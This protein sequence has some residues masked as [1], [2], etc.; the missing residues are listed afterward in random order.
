[1]HTKTQAWFWCKMLWS[2]FFTAYAHGL[3]CDPRNCVGALG[4][5][6]K[7]MQSSFLSQ[8]P[9]VCEKLNFPDKSNKNVYWKTENCEHKM[10]VYR[11]SSGKFFEILMF[12]CNKTW[13][14]VRL[15]S[16]SCL[17]LVMYS[18]CWLK[19][20]KISIDHYDFTAL[21]PPINER[22]GDTEKIH[23]K[24]RLIFHNSFR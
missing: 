8:M 1:M 23:L 9:L 11:F 6:H 13:D 17:E 19:S 14:N 2:Y 10:I 21:L 3:E 15:H 16:L 7:V 18:L 4:V 12:I 24:Y 20:S 5:T 22:H